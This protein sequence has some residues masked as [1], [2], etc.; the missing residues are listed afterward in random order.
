MSVPSLA[1][2]LPCYNEEAAIAKVVSDFA[3]H[4]PEARIC[5]FDN[6]ST[7]NTVEEARKA[8]AEIF[9]V[10]QRGKGNVVSRMFADVDADIYI[11]ADGDGTYEAS[12]APEMVTLLQRQ[13]L[14]MV[15]GVRTAT[16]IGETSRRGHRF[17][18]W[19]LTTA[20]NMLFRAKIQDMLSGYRVIRRRLVKTLPIM[21][22]GF[23]VETEMTIHV[24]SLRLPYL[25]VET[26]YFERHEDSHSKLQTYRDGQRILVTLIRL[27][28]DYKPMLFFS[29]LAGMLLLVALILF[30]P[31]LTE[32]IELGTVS[33][34]PT[35]VLCTGL[36]LS[37]LLMFM[38]GFV[39]DSVS[40]ARLENKILAYLQNKS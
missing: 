12:R 34:L 5:V 22:Q 19:L 15:V 28:K 11:M 29:I 4:L 17:G 30:Q 36:G 13:N 3:Q 16:H 8:G 25:E 20:T 35:A 6:N 31:L 24:L 37:G 26:Q 33:R 40:Q 32:Y 7:D 39:L 14:D 2:I 21:S 9:H 1:V 18:N 27:F 10:A 23:E 38:V